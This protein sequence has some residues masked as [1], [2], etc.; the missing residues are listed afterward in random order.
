M[1]Y[2]TLIIGAGPI[3]LACGIEAQVR[4]LSYV[5]IE[6]G[7][8]VNSIYHYPIQM[9]FFS[10]SD[11]IEI[12]GVPF[13][14]HHAKPTRSE[15][16]EYY[17]RVKQKYTLNV[18]TYEAVTQ[19]NQRAEGFEVISEKD[20]YQARTVVIATGF[21][22]KPNM[23]GIPGE[24]LPKVT[25]YYKE[26]HPYVDREIVVVGARNSA[27]DVALE[28]YR[29][30]AKV[31]MVI[32]EDEIHPKV[33]Y[34]VRP[35]IVNRIKEGSIKAYFDSKLTA[36]RAHEVEVQTPDGVE[37][38]PND[39]VLAMTGYQPD[40]PFL[41]AVGLQF[42]AD[43]MRY[44]IRHEETF[45]SSVPDVYLAGTVCGGMHTNKWFIENSIEH[46][47]K[48]MEAIVDRRKA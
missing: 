4:G 7:C 31:T 16:L 6:K 46:A 43:E 12:G 39:F 28:T 19:V 14:A 20:T 2:D 22:D 25:H 44:P 37:T 36:I 21:Y 42:S 32:R 30:G 48:V 34:W 26:A 40:F 23:M 11:K 9:T 41:E 8:L 47:A 24:D 1:T 13:V 27:V 35:D 10:T 15:A 5:I 33:K 3:G 38:I 45:E 29:K 17:R 18:R